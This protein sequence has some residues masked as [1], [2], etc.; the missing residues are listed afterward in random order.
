MNEQLKILLNRVDDFLERTEEELELGRFQEVYDSIPEKQSLIRD[1]L[2][3]LEYIEENPLDILYGFT[4]R[5]S[6]KPRFGMYSNIIRRG[7]IRP[8]RKKKNNVDN[9]SIPLRFGFN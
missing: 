8:H 9:N 3:G 5:R 7:E 2:D 4:P 6:G 1:Y